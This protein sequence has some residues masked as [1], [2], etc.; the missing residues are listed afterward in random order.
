MDIFVRTW[1]MKGGYMFS[2]RKTSHTE[3][4]GTHIDRKGQ[5]GSKPIIIKRVGSMVSY[6]GGKPVTP[7]LG[8]GA[9]GNLVMM[10]GNGTN[11][12]SLG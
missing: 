6:D 5:T 9:K 10:W 4:T 3:V 1:E 12:Y 8:S 11:W 2:C 7:K